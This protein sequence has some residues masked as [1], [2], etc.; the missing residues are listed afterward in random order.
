MLIAGTMANL[1]SA[2]NNVRWHEMYSM[3]NCCNQADFFYSELSSLI[4]KITPVQTI[5][6][7][8]FDRPWV[9]TYFKKLIL[10]IDAEFVSGNIALF[11]PLSPGLPDYN[12]PVTLS[13]LAH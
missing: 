4:D 6:F 9:T 5:K 13:F 2:I 8:A 3:D 1:A 12:N 10:S 7:K 11:N